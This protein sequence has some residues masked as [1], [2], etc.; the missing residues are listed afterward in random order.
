[1][2]YGFTIKQ[3]VLDGEKVWVAES[4]DLNG[5]V[6]QGY[7]IEEAIQELATN[8]ET[9]LAVAEECGI[10]IPQPTVVAEKAEY[11]GKLTLRLGTRLHKETSECARKDG[12]S[13]NNYISN[14]VASYNSAKSTANVAAHMIREAEIKLSDYFSARY[15]IEPNMFN[16]QASNRYVFMPR[17]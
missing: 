4:A 14:A 11:S 17:S 7:S 3:C 13:I 9:W 1:M 5:C 2:R 15:R 8:E 16:P 12:L 10:E 6:A